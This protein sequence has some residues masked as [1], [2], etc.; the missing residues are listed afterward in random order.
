VCFPRARNVGGATV[1]ALQDMF[2]AGGRELKV[3]RNHPP[4]NEERQ[5]DLSKDN[6]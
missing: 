4:L 5:I 2:L 6:E 1:V 3:N